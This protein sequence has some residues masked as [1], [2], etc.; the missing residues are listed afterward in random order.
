MMWAL[1][2]MYSI[3]EYLKKKKKR[4]KRI[5]ARRVSGK[6]GRGRDGE[7]KRSADT[8]GQ[9]EADRDRQRPAS[10]TPH[11]PLKHVLCG[12]RWGKVLNAFAGMG[13]GR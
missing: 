12:C 6:V 2:C 8:L 3:L 5:K 11:T 7:R 9:K 1:C 10:R 4:K 13:E